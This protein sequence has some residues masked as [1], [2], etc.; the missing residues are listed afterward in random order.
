MQAG[1]GIV[2]GTCIIEFKLIFENN[3]FLSRLNLF[4]NLVRK[5]NECG[6]LVYNLDLVF[7]D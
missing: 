5:M 6:Q 2:R 1:N 3:A 7:S 4:M